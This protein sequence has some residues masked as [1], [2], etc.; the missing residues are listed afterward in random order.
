MKLNK[1]NLKN[2]YDTISSLFSLNFIVA[3][4]DRD[5]ITRLNNIEL[6]DCIK[7]DE[8][9]MIKVML[10]K[11]SLMGKNS[12]CYFESKM[13]LKYISFSVY[14][15]E[16]Y[17][18]GI[19]IGPYINYPIQLEVVDSSG[20]RLDKVIPIIKILQEKAIENIVISMINYQIEDTN[21]TIMQEDIIE[22][23]DTNK[24]CY[25][26]EFDMSLINIRERYKLENKLLHYVSMGDS[27]KASKM[28]GIGKNLIFD[29]NR[30]PDEP[31]RNIKN[32]AITMNTLLRKAVQENNIEPYVLDSISDYF[33]KRIEKSNKVNIIY[34]IFEEM[35]KEYC[36]LV[37]EYKTKGYSKLV[38]NAINYIKLNFKYEISL[39]SI[40][41][42]LFVHP[43]YLAKKFKGETYKTISE[44]INEIRAKEAKIMLKTTEFKIEDIAYYVGYNDKKYFSK[45]FKKIYNQSPSDYRKYN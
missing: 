37:N 36:N 41:D 33:A 27:D 43:T 31:V 26:K 14:S 17:E 40:A 22:K 13:K 16:N 20:R 3:Y 15:N 11:T 30:F 29:I 35:I 6:P 10:E 32:F 23:E 12:V 5:E 7:E 2:I 38:S 4:N 42:E 21:V 24:N 8:I 25:I 34:S 28:I 45:V 19:I 18:G 44:Y 9:K 39:S 1:S